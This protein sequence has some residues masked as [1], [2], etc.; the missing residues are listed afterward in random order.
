MMKKQDVINKMD[1]IVARLIIEN[2]SAGA[3]IEDAKSQAFNRLNKEYPEALA[4][5]LA[6]K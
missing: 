2:I 6:A 4:L 3:N 5:W 1:N